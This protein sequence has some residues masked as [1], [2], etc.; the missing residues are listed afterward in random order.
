MDQIN[1]EDINQMDEAAINLKKSF[2]IERIITILASFALI[3]GLAGCGTKSMVVLIPDNEGNV[4]KVVV[5]TEGGQQLLDRGNQSVEAKGRI[6]PP[7]KVKVL[8]SDEINAT[9]SEALAAQP[10][11]PVKF[12]LYFLQN[13]NELTSESERVVPQIIQTIKD[14]GSIDIVISGH[15]DTAGTME[16][17]DKLSLER[18]RVM[19]DILV[20]NGALS[21]NIT[22][23]SH[24][25]GNPLIKTDDDVEEPKN[26]RVEVVIK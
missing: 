24:G 16:H 5:S 8:T 6:A 19:H 14:R 12:I 1:G 23:T 17:N 20:A 18:A 10:L 2:N 11:P 7:G 25:E 15:T 4:G 26:R 22:V 9:F 3:W 21:S 13:S